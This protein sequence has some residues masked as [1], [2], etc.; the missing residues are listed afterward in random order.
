MKK[1]EKEEFLKNQ[2]KYLSPR[3]FLW[4]YLKDDLDHRVQ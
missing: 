3:L 2:K 1:N 4:Q